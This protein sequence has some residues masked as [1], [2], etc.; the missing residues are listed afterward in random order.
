MDSSFLSNKT[1]AV[2]GIDHETVLHAFP[3]CTIVSWSLRIAALVVGSDVKDRW[4]V[5][6]AKRHKIP[7]FPLEKLHKN[8]NLWA[9]TYAPK[10]AKEIIGNSDSIQALYE[11]L[12]GWTVAK[13]RAVLITGPPGIGKTTAASLVAKLCKFSIV[14]LNA[15]TERSAKAIKDVFKDAADA[16]HV[17]MKRVVIMDEV[18]GMSSGDRGGIGALAAITKTCSFPIIC[19]ANERGTPRLRPLT[20]ACKEIKF[21]RPVRSTIAKTLMTSVVAKEGLK[22]TQSDLEELCERNGNDIRQILNFLQFHLGSAG[23]KGK[24]VSKD[25]LLRID[26]F[27][28]TGRLF[29]VEGTA[30]SRSEYAWVDYSMVPLMVAEGY[31]GAAAKSRG[32]D[33]ERLE[34]CVAAADLLTTYDLMDKRIHRSQAWGL[35][36][37]AM[38]TVSFAAS[39]CKGPAPF[40]IF[41]SLLGKMSK[42]AKHLRLYKELAR[43][44]ST[45]EVC[46]TV[47]LLRTRLFGLKDADSICDRLIGYGLTRDMMMDTLTET[48]FTGDEKTVAMDSKLKSAVTRAWKK[49]NVEPVE[50]KTDGEDDGE[51]AYDSD[52][53]IDIL[54]E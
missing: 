4:K 37:A 34:R 44:R 10:H 19:I 52:D 48:I 20:S 1:I 8:T 46:D 21:S 12:H 38:M 9:D 18:D 41:P 43:G 33:T 7:I 32:S 22:I 40:Q 13:E 3:S 29:G 30:V 11:W 27:S 6:A 23:T 17:G 49:R 25:E 47:N 45:L 39:A 28:A 50:S 35:L 31:I 54:D 2:S 16:G 42:R 51:D 5:L 53:A 26:V 15:S 24:L 36:P 14:E